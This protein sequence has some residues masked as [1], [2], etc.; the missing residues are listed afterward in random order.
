VVATGALWYAARGTEGSGV[1]ALVPPGHVSVV[2]N[3][4]SRPW[5][6]V[7]TFDITP[8]AFGNY[9]SG[10]IVVT[11]VRPN[12]DS[13]GIVYRGSFLLSA[14]SSYS[15][16]SELY[17][18]Q[19]PW[20]APWYFPRSAIRPAE[21]VR[22]DSVGKLKNFSL[23]NGW[24]KTATPDHCPL[25]PPWIWEV[26]VDILRPGNYTVHGFSVT[27]LQNRVSYTEPLPSPQFRF[28]FRVC[29][30][31]AKPHG[32]GTGTSSTCTG[33]RPLRVARP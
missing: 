3:D 17:Q 12:L 6:P 2:T 19:N 22:L 8:G 31:P 13:S 4:L 29:G 15:H 25:R 28:L 14:C 20:S 16:L 26:R 24:W 5:A 23:P 32:R 7:G 33:R 21:P 27:Y 1:D 11:E 9:S 10:P 30:A 18:P